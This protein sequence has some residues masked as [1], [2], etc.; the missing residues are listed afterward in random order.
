MNLQP[1][2]RGIVVFVL[3][4]AFFAALD[5]TVKYVS[6]FLPLVTTLWIRYLVQTLITAGLMMPSRGRATWEINRL[7]LV[8][9]RGFMLAISGGLAFVSLSLMPVAEYSA[10]IMLTPMLLTLVSAILLKERVSRTN[11]LLL[12]GALAGALLVIQPGSAGFGWVVLLPLILIVL[13]VAYQLLTRHLTSH[14]DPGSMHLYSGLFSMLLV[15]LALPFGWQTPEGWNAWGLL[16]LLS[17]FSAVGHYLMIVAYSLAGPATL[18]PFIYLQLVFA[19]LAGWLVFEHT[20]NPLAWLGM[21]LIALCGI[22][23]ARLPQPASEVP[24]ATATGRH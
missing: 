6:A 20:P 13:N 10:I 22:I 11:W 23:S 18:S 2:R 14:M 24:P 4:M 5:T 19:T 12:A 1:A 21:A 17:L 8:M 3:A 15:S 7:G 9:L 16:L